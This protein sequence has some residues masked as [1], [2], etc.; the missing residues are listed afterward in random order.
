MPPLLYVQVFVVLIG[1]F[2]GSFLGVLIDRLARQEDVVRLPSSCRG[3]ANRL[4][5]LD[6]IPIVSFARRRGRCRHCDAAIPAWLLYVELLAAGAAVLAVI[7]GY[8]IGSTLLFMVFLWVLI[9][10]A[11]A[12]LLWMRLPDI[13]TAALAV[14]AMGLALLPHGIGLWQALIGASIG[15]ASFAVLRFVYYRFRGVH[16]LGLGDVKLMV[17]LGACVG[18]LQLPLLVFVAAGTALVIAVLQRFHDNSA[19]NATR[20][21]PFGAALCGAAFVLWILQLN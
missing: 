6:L 11:G 16:G 2:V 8:D 10:L 13:L 3:C 15:A 7:A 21:L 12:D 4:G 1:P 9:A 5:S 20:A 17:G 19:L 14:I 18:P